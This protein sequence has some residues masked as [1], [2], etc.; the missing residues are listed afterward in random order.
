MDDVEPN[1]Y[2]EET[3]LVVTLGGPIA[4]SELD[5]VVWTVVVIARGAAL[6]V[7][8]VVEFRIQMP[9]QPNEPLEGLVKPIQ[10]EVG[11]ANDQ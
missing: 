10:K 8:G 6:A 11:H 1:R 9:T 7:F 2:T 5:F 3:R 4:R